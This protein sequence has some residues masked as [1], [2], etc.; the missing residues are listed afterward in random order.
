[1][2]P[3]K[4]P[5]NGATKRRAISPDFKAKKTVVKKAKKPIFIPRFVFGV[6]TLKMI[7]E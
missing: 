2:A 6:K 4:R 5:R 1:M 3:T 7:F